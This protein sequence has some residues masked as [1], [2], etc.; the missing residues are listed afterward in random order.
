MMRCVKLYRRSR[1]FEK[2]LLLR[3][4]S[5]GTL[6]ADE[7]E[8]LVRELASLSDTLSYEVVREGNPDV[9]IS[10]CSAEGKDLGLRFTVFPA[11]MNLI[12][13]FWHSTMQQVPGRMWE[14]P[15]SSA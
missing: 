2:P 1:S 5:D 6:L 14:K 15:C 11:G 4:S 13:L 7:A 8:S 12:P 9:T 10:I 3:V